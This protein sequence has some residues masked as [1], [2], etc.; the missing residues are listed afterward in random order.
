MGIKVGT[1]LE[2]RYGDRRT[3][4]ARDHDAETLCVVFELDHADVITA[5]DIKTYG[6]KVVK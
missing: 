4:T 5:A 1:V 2:G 3:V 6:L